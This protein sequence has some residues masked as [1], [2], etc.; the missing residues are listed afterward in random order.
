MYNR[1]YPYVY[2]RSEKPLAPPPPKPIRPSKKKFDFKCF[3]NDTCK[4]LND[5]EY[6]LNKFTSTW[7]YI[8]LINLLK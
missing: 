8:R 2:N 3:K 5:V 1:Y 7:K 6:F 4:S